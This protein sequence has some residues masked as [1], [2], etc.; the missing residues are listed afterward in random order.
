MILKNIRKINLLYY[1]FILFALDYILHLAFNNGNYN[2][3]HVVFFDLTIGTFMSFILLI[4]KGIIKRVIYF[5]MNIIVLLYSFLV[6]IEVF[7]KIN[8]DTSYPIKTI[9][10]NL[11]NVITQY[12]DEILDIVEKHIVLIFIFVLGIVLFFIVSKLLFLFDENINIRKFIISGLIIIV[13]ATLSL[14]TVNKNITNWTDNLTVNGLKTAIIFDLKNDGDGY[15]D[16]IEMDIDNYLM[17]EEDNNV[18]KDSA[19]SDTANKKI[20]IKN[21]IPADFELDEYNILDYD[22]EELNKIETRVDF[23]RTNNYLS[24]LPATKKNKY[25]GL[26]KN[27]N[28]IMICAEAWNSIIVDEKLFPT[29]YR[30]IHNGFRFNN[31]YQ[32]HSSSS[33]SS[34]EFSFMTGMI[35][36][37]DDYSFRDCIE[38]NMSFSISSKLHDEGYTTYSFHNGVSTYYSRDETHGKLL[39]FDEFFANDTGLFEILHKQWPDDIELFDSTFDK[40]PKDKPFMAYYMTYTAHM[41]YDG[42][43]SRQYLEYKDKIEAVYGNTKSMVFKNYVAKNMLLEVALT[44]LVDNLEKN[45]MLNDTVICMVPDHYP[46]GLYR[47]NQFTHTKDNYV[48]ELYNDENID[49]DREIRDKTDIILWCGSLENEDKDKVLEIDKPTCTIDLTPTLLNLF[50]LDFDSRIYPGH[51]MFSSMEG[52]VIYQDGRFVTKDYVCRNSYEEVPAEYTVYRNKV[53]NANNY[54]KFNIKNDYYGY[55]VGKTGETKKICYLMFEGGPSDNTLKIL[56]IL[57]EEKVNATFFISENQKMEY[58]KLI[59]KKEHKIG[60][61]LDNVDLLINKENEKFADKINKLFSKI[62]DVTKDKAYYVHFSKEVKNKIEK[63]NDVFLLSQID[64]QLTKLSLK[65]VEENV[66]SKD[67]TAPITRDEIVHN[68]LTNLDGKEHIFVLLHDY[69]Y[70]DITVDALKQIIDGIKYKGYRFKFMDQIT[71]ILNE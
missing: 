29:M 9:I 27:K 42:D 67:L 61:C 63:D 34:G 7:L 36:V 71:K 5:I 39:D 18:K 17:N 49:D 26:F 35:P 28:L 19:K 57:D 48:A 54:C 20:V 38:N 32:P 1:S 68:V 22:F 64:A 10:S 44:N 46:Y 23:I 53:I 65:V 16:F 50:G 15:V 40:L 41:P 60:I 30:L 69:D 58:L 56:D 24:T 14:L 62:L 12:N 51:D 11:S 13:S 47:S 45:N 25:T 52:I 21:E 37:E 43:E 8:Y 66:D 55:L 59:S 6:M 70:T 2:L 3:L 4:S 33:T 31:F